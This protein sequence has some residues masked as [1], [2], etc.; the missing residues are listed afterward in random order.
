MDKSLL[1]HLFKRQHNGHENS[2]RLLGCEHAVGFYVVA[3]AD[4]VE[5]F[6]YYIGGAVFLKEVDNVDDAEL[7]CELCKSPCFV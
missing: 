7:A 1:M 4:A 3:E 6:H 2:E 5:V